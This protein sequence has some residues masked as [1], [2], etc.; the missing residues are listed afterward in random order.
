MNEAGTE[1]SRLG[2]GSTLVA[3]Y[4]YQALE[5]R[6]GAEGGS[7]S[8]VRREPQRGSAAE[9]DG[10]ASQLDRRDPILAEFARA[11]FHAGTLLGTIAS[12]E[13]AT[14]QRRGEPG[15]RSRF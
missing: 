11:I 15:P 4:S 7:A 13:W 1:I 9:A 8:V 12:V 6:R 10:L 3:E 2:T 14:V 5:A